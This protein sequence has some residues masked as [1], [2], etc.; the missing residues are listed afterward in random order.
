MFNNMFPKIVPF[1]S[2]VENYGTAGQDTRYS[3]LRRMRSACWLTKAT[4][5]HQ[6]FVHFCFSTTMITHAS[7]SVL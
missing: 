4:D 7:L 2:N 1:M 5:T 3:I 6:E